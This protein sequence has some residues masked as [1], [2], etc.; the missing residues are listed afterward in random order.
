MKFNGSRGFHRR[1]VYQDATPLV[2]LHTPA[3]ILCARETTRVLKNKLLAS[4]ALGLAL[5]ASANAQTNSYIDGNG[6][7]E[8]S[9]SWS[10]SVAPSTNDMADVITTT[11]SSTITIDS[12]TASSFPSAMT[13][14]NLTIGANTLQLTNVSPA[15]FQILNQF[16]LTT[17][18]SLLNNGGIFTITGP[19]EIDQGTLT[20]ASGTT[21][22]SSNLLVGSSVNSTGTINVTGGQLVVTNGVIG[23]GDDG[24]TTNGFGV[25]TMTVTN[26]TVLA[27][28]ILLGSCVGGVGTLNILTNGVINLVGSNAM[29]V[30]DGTTV[31]ITGGSVVINNG[32][33]ACGVGSPSAI[34]MSGGTVS[35][36]FLNAGFNNV[37]TL[38][39]SAGQITVSSTLIVGGSKPSGAGTVLMNGG[40]LIANVNTTAIGDLGT[41]T[42]TLNSGSTAT[43]HAL[44]LGANG[45]IGRVYVMGGTLNV[46][47]SSITV[48]AGVCSLCP[49]VMIPG[50]IIASSDIDTNGCS[51]NV[52]MG[53]NTIGQITISNGVVLAG[54]LVMTNGDS[55][56]FAFPGGTLSSGG[57]VV[58]NNQLFLVG[59]GTDAATFQLN[60]GVHSFANNLEI[61]NN[62]TLSGCGT[63]SGN[64]AFDNGGKV[65]A[66]CGTLTFT[67]IVT[68]NGTMQAVNGNVL[69]FNGPVFNSGVIDIING[70]PL[71]F[72]NTFSNSG[73]VLDASSVVISSVARSNTDVIVKIQSY[74][75]HTYQL[76]ITPSL[77]PTNWT[78]SGTLQDG[79]GSMLSFTDTG[80]AT[81]KPGRFY[82]IDV[83]AQ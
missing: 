80:G 13:I 51:P 20:S 83:G 56:E 31:N 11:N 62:G 36:A 45:G 9:N 54:S 82:R 78:N 63:I 39:M 75:G 65:L 60:G 76:E 72:S 29:L 6:K 15:V 10:R 43:F 42:L 77:T 53:S 73:T 38:T 64:A 55:S 52:T 71:I 28:Q 18:A 3:R 50:S 22:F 70:G 14:N 26:G 16:V 41:G 23:I 49:Q 33:F 46:P 68:N 74:T 61:A 69:Q 27:S 4:I 7:W 1:A 32:S 66:N 25:G 58:S 24:T 40:K 37:G 12:T 2:C 79:T 44:V 48:D 35:C 57:T 17:G 59:D 47:A 8:T 81:N 34:N 19:A 67:G 30:A 21:Q 5:I